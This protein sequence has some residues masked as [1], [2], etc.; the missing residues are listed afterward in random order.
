MR[1]PVSTLYLLG[2]VRLTRLGIVH[3]FNSVTSTNT[4]S[5]WVEILVPPSQKAE[6]RSQGLFNQRTGPLRRQ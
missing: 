6:S 4:V 5:S 1:E 3:G 2:F